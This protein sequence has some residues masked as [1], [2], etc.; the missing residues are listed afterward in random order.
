M[1]A[2][3]SKCASGYSAA[4]GFI[5]DG[6]KFNVYD[7]CS[8]GHGVRAYLD[9]NSNGIWIRY[10]SKYNGNGLN[11]NVVMSADLLTGTLYRMRI[12][13]VD[14]ASDTTPSGCSSWVLVTE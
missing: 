5:D 11:T 1:Y 8:D 7:M 9:G 6:D 2:N 13:T 14:G 3:N 4:L 12:C 10:N